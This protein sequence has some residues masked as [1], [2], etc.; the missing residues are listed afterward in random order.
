MTSK[1]IY[2]IIKKLTIYFQFHLK[3]NIC[4][5]FLCQECKISLGYFCLDVSPKVVSLLVD[6][7]L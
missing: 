5:I 6:L 1:P 7:L 2:A 4:V 3:S